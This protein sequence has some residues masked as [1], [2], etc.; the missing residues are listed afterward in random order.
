MANEKVKVPVKTLKNKVETTEQVEVDVQTDDEA[1]AG[2]FVRYDNLLNWLDGTPGS[3]NEALDVL[4]KLITKVGLYPYAAS[5]PLVWGDGTP[6]SLS[7]AIDALAAKTLDPKSAY[8][9]ADPLA[10]ADVGT[11]STIGEA[12]DMLRAACC[13][14][15]EDL[16]Y[17]PTAE[18]LL[19]WVGG[20]PT[21]MGQALSILAARATKG[22][23]VLDT[24][25]LTAGD[26]ATAKPVN[27]TEA[28]N[29]LA[30]AVKAL[31]TGAAIP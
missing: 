17:A 30:S 26:W 7:E 3:L 12:L 23:A 10:W 4:K 20:S 6:V 15:V 28:L 24:S 22:E 25:K 21:K 13:T 8:S 14:Q 29:R 1:V 27:L 19:N 16:P 2:E 11:P 9:P 5:N 31:R 18:E